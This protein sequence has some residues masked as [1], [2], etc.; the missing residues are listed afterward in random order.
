[1]SY[2]TLPTMTRNILTILFSFI[3][4]LSFAQN[5]EG[6]IIY[7]DKFN[8]HMS[9][10]PEMEAMKDRIPEFR[11]SE[12]ILTFKGN[13]AL[14]TKYESEE[15]KPAEFSRRRGFRW[16]GDDVNEFYTNT[17]DNT[18]VDRK[19]FFGKEFLIEGEREKLAWKI[20]TE[21]KQV[22][23]YLCQ[24]AILRDSV[25]TTEVW[26]TPMI[27]VTVGPDEY[28]GL[29]GMILHVNIDDGKRTITAQ[30]IDL[31]ALEEEIKR[32]TK[33]KKVTKEEFEEIRET[34]IKEM[35][36]EYGGNRRG[37]WMRRY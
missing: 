8:I 35:E 34:K 37:Y 26:F 29:P 6:I 28:Y 12:K 3:S 33:G 14:Y 7:E 4:I 17:G 27:P 10:S 1:M 16:G 36:Q 22:G 25:S 30:S 15:K 5:N 32:P 11:T 2:S 21:Q 20:T 18:S 23:S 9:L 13:E 19:T 24:K 31:V